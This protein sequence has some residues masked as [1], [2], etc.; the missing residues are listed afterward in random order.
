MS[1]DETTYKIVRNYLRDE[2]D[3]QVIQTGLSLV[4]A[5][6]HCKNPETSSRTCKQKENVERTQRYGAWFDSYTDEG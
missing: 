3:S 1:E 4:E 6:A 5:R 2:Y